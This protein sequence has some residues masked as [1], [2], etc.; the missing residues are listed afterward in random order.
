MILSL[1]HFP[2]S[3]PVAQLVACLTFF[4]WFCLVHSNPSGVGSSNSAEALK[5][6]SFDFQFLDII[7]VYSSNIKPKSGGKTAGHWVHWYLETFEQCVARPSLDRY[8]GLDH[9]YSIWTDFNQA[10]FC[11][12]I[13]ETILELAEGSGSYP[14]PCPQENVYIRGSLIKTEVID[15]NWE[16]CGEYLCTF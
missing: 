16:Q 8:F 3:L 7:Y 6:V 9:V 12:C 13:G 14:L 2:T 4:L 1:W 11:V 5:F 15:G 10:F